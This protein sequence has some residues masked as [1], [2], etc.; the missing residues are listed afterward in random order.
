MLRQTNEEY[1]KQY[2]ED[3]R[4][5]KQAWEE[6]TKRNAKEAYQHPGGYRWIRVQDTASGTTHYVEAGMTGCP[7]AM[8]GRC[9]NS[10]KLLEVMAYFY[11]HG[12]L[13]SQEW[14][15]AQPGRD[16]WGIEFREKM[17]YYKELQRE[18]FQFQPA[19]VGHTE[20]ITGIVALNEQ[21]GSVALQFEQGIQVAAKTEI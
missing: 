14:V 3:Q 9:I 1:W 20:G 16:R 15:R 19:T 7:L 2:H 6:E 21:G 17:G 12:R 11:D 10:S 5:A 4:K 13:P 18:A 8:E